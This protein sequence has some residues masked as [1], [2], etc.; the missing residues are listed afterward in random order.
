MQIADAR[1]SDKDKCNKQWFQLEVQSLS[2][3]AK[4]TNIAVG[5]MFT[6]HALL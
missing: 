3:L 5:T 1:C 4:S 6:V 2:N